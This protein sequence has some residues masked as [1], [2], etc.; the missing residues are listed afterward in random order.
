M[1]ADEKRCA[2]ES[3]MKEGDTVLLKQERK[4]KLMPTFRPEPYRV[5][6]KSGKSVVVQSPDGVQ[7][8]RNSSHVKKFLERNS[9]P[10]NKRSSPPSASNGSTGHQAQPSV[11]ESDKHLGETCTQTVVASVAEPDSLKDTILRS[12]RSRTLP[13][14]FK[15]FV[16]S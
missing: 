1:Y 15:D 8:K 12:T 7:Y 2:R 14:R 6:D 4:N 5:L 11:T 13:A 10:E 9:V 3:D 16:M